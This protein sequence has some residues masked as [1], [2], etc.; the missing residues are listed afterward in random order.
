MLRYRLRMQRAKAAQPVSFANANTTWK[1][2]DGLFLQLLSEDGALG[3]GEASPLPQYSP[4]SIEECESFCQ[5]T[6]TL[7]LPQ[8][9]IPSITRTLRTLPISLPSLRFAIETALLDLLSQERNTSISELLGA[10]LSSQA[11]CG[12][13]NLD[14]PLPSAQALL[15]RG[16]SCAKYKVGRDWASEFKTIVALRSQFPELQLRLDANGAWSLPVALAN[17]Q[18]L[19]PLG[20]EFVE[21][22]VVP[23]EMA[24]LAQSPTPIAADE[25]MHS[26]SGRTQ[27]RPLLNSNTLRAIVLKPTV[28]GGLATCLDHASW[29]R[30][31]GMHAIV[32]H[33]FEGPIATAALC[34]LALAVGGEAPVGIDLHNALPAF[35]AATIPQLT[36]TRITSHALGLGVRFL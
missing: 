23:S 16:L 36:S 24:G 8:L 29:A 14:A 31:H 13:L 32:S 3:Q 34:E 10:P 5:I 30:H 22:P 26:E 11:R 15:D 35:A 20:I 21:Q 19:A 9:D 4:D 33:C 12:L 28:L 17:L 27:L 7:S 1:A 6:P 25:S 2:R 18:E